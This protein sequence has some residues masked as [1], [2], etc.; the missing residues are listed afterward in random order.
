MAVE[1]TNENTVDRR[2]EAVRPLLDR[3]QHVHYRVL[4]YN[5]LADGR[6]SC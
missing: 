2:T 4:P 1:Y 5:A 6:P 3:S